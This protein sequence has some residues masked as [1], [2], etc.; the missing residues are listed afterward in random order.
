MQTA[1][2]VPGDSGRLFTV[3]P[4]QPVYLFP[5]FHSNHVNRTPHTPTQPT[6]EALALK[7]TEAKFQLSLKTKL[8]SNLLG[9][10][11][12]LW[13]AYTQSSRWQVYTGGISRP[14]RESNY[15]P[16]AMFVWKTNHQLMGVRMPF[17]SIGINHQSNGRADPLSRSWNRV[18][19]QVG[20]EK[21]SWTATLRLW[22]RI[23]ERVD[24]D[25]NPDIVKFA[26]RGDLLV[27]K[28]MGGHQLTALVRP[29][30]TGGQQGALR[31]DWAFPL[32]GGLKGHVQWFN[33]Y[34]ESLIDYNHRSQYLGLG[35][36]LVEWY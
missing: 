24:N 21:D 22:Q 16:E 11:G 25:D 20:F 8:A 30:L 32:Q 6:V 14:F 27:T 10:N 34:G 1:W 29:A 31:L 28:T 26:G 9:D 23:K 2:G 13:G 36:S 7:G 18:I 15:E 17:T 19:G 3:R 5:V 4:Y 33:G 35:V 12:D